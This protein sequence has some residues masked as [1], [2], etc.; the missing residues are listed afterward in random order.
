MEQDPH[1]SN[2]TGAK[3]HGGQIMIIALVVSVIFIVYLSHFI[4]QS[5]TYNMI[6][7]SQFYEQL[8]KGHV[9]SVVFNG[10]QIEG[11]FDPPLETASTTGETIKVESFRTY[12]PP[13]PD[14]KLFDLLQQK[15]VTI[16]TRRKIAPPGGG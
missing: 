1:T 7:Y 16:E 4:S 11:V 5:S 6:S 9:S 12:L 13:I 3:D 15:G 14:N 10:Q 8:E 2:N